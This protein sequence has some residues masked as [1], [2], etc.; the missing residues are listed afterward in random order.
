[1][2]LKRWLISDPVWKTE[3]SMAEKAK[4]DVAEKTAVI[5]QVLKPTHLGLLTILTGRPSNPLSDISPFHVGYFETGIRSRIFVLYM[6]AFIHVNY[7]FGV[8]LSLLPTHSILHMP[9]FK[10][11]MVFW[12]GC[13]LFPLWVAFGWHSSL[14]PPTPALQPKIYFR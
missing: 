8:S 7:F 5:K 14:P 13:A 12:S 9:R 6:G 4:A 2:K 10:K 1:M 11:Q 3:A